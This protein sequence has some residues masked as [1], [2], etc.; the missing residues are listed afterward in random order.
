[1][2]DA[3]AE[4]MLVLRFQYEIGRADL[5]TGLKD[6]E[7]RQT[8]IIIQLQHR[9]IDAGLGDRLP[10]ER[11]KRQPQGVVRIQTVALRQYASEPAL[12]HVD[13]DL[14]VLDRLHRHVCLRENET[15][16]TVILRDAVC[17]RL[18]F[19]DGET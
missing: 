19:A 4:A 18:Q 11:V 2:A 13:N 15:V 9:T 3:A 7:R 17:R 12:Q 6:A 5:F 16:L 8:G 10:D 1:E 14:A